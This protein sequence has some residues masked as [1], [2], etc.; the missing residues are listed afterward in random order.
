[1]FRPQYGNNQIPMGYGMQNP[2]MRM[3]APNPIIP[4]GMVQGNI[5]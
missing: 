3:F 5:P 4:N 2:A 1:M